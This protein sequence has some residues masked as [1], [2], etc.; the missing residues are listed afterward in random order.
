MLTTTSLTYLRMSKKFTIIALLAAAASVA[1]VSCSKEREDSPANFYEEITKTDKLVLASMTINKIG[2][3]DDES[4]WK[5]GKRI[6]V[7][8]YNTYLTAYID[9]SQLSPDDI[10]ID[11]KAGTAEITLPP[12]QTEYSGRD[13]SMKE[14]HYRVTGL[15]SQIGPKERAELKEEM[16]TTLKKEVKSDSNFKSAVVDAAKRKAEIFFKKLFAQRDLNFT[17]NFK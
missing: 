6:A 9:L 13:I 12:V 3:Y 15:R 1:A 10:E 16:N 7:Y 5:I 14:E 4:D 2:E 8:S 17:V 11:E